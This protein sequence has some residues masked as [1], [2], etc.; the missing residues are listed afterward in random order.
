MT[1]IF[2]GPKRYVQRPGALAAAGAE[3]KA[4]GRH[5][6]ILGDEL[7]LYILRPVLEK[8]L[9]SAGLSACREGLRRTCATGGS[10]HNLNLP[11]DEKSL[12]RALQEVEERVGKMRR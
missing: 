7:V 3:L 11:A 4:F 8:N 10:A 9:R 5:P 6:M 2:L 1:D 12:L